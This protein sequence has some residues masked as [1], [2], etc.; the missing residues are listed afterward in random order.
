MVKEHWQNHNTKFTEGTNAA[1]KP[2]SC[3]SFLL[4]FTLIDFHS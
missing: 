3:F 1:P 4:K 2:N